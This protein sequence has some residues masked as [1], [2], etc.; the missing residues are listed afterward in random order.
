[1]AR[2]ALPKGSS[3][4]DFGIVLTGRRD[5]VD[6][7]VDVTLSDDG[8]EI[9]FLTRVQQAKTGPRKQDTELRVP[10]AALRRALTLLSP[11]SLEEAM[12]VPFSALNPAPQVVAPTGV[13]MTADELQIG[14]VPVVDDF[15]PKPQPP[16]EDA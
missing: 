12:N 4:D 16:I 14:G 8:D 13:P 7:K 9:V 2:Q 10:L 6:A 11:V 5:G 1:M 15:T 3:L